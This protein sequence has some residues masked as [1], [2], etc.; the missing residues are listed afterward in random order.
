MLYYSFSS[1]NLFIIQGEPL[2]YKGHRGFC[3]SV[4]S[5][6]YNQLQM[7]LHLLSGLNVTLADKV[8]LGPPEESS[9][10]IIGS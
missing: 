2:L 10:D 4:S 8:L 3:S 7:T 1:T 6:L 5:N 9:S